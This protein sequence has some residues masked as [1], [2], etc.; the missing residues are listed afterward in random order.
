MWTLLIILAAGLGWLLCSGDAPSV[1]PRASEDVETPGTNAPLDPLDATGLKGRGDHAKAEAPQVELPAPPATGGIVGRVI[2]E[3]SGEGIARVRLFALRRPDE[4]VPDG[5][6]PRVAFSTKDGS[7]RFARVPAG[8]WMV[9]TFHKDYTHPLYG[10]LFAPSR[11]TNRSPGRALWAKATEIGGTVDVADAEAHIEL[12]LAPGARLNGRVVDGAGAPV[13]GAAV[14]VKTPMWGAMRDL[15]S[16]VSGWVQRMPLIQTGDDGAFSLACFPLMIRDLH[17]APSHERLVGRWSKAIRIADGGDVTLTLLEPATIEGSVTWSDGRPEPEADVEVRW[18]TWQDDSWF[19]RA[20]ET[21]TD[22][23]GAFRLER[24]PPGAIRLRARAGA[25]R[26]GGAEVELLDLQPGESRTGVVLQL[27]DDRHLRGVLRRPDGTPLEGEHIEAYRNFEDDV[28]LGTD[29]TDED[30]SFLIELEGRQP[31]ELWL[32]TGGREVRLAQDVQ[33]PRDDLQLTAEPTPRHQVTVRV[34][35]PDG[36]PVPRFR[37]RIEDYAGYLRGSHRGTNGAASR[38]VQGDGPFTL[39]IDRMQDEA[40]EALPYPPVGMELPR[41][42]PE[43]I[44]VRVSEIP[45]FLGRVTDDHDKPVPGI[46]LM[47]GTRE[48]KLDERGHFRFVHD[49]PKILRV[50]DAELILPPGYRD[51]TF[52]GTLHAGRFRHMWVH[53]GGATLRGKVEVAGAGSLEGLRI[54]VAWPP[55]EGQ[56]DYEATA[57]IDTN[58]AGEFVF[59]ALPE[60]VEVTVEI[61][62][63]SL[64]DAGLYTEAAPVRAASH[65]TGVVLRAKRGLT[66]TGRFEGP[67]LADVDVARLEAFPLRWFGFPD[68]ARGSKPVEGAPHAFRIGGLKSGTYRL[69]VFEKAGGQGMLALLPGVQAGAKDVVVR[70]PR[71]DGVITGSV[72]TKWLAETMPNRAYAWAQDDSVWRVQ[73]KID[74][75]GNFRFE[76]LPRGV[77]YTVEFASTQGAA[78]QMAS[79]ADVRPG[80]HVTLEPTPA[81]WITGRLTR[82]AGA[83]NVE[84]IWALGRWTRALDSLNAATGA[85]RIGPLAPGTYRLITVGEGLKKL[86]AHGS[87]QAGDKDVEI[88]LK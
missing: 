19:A 71:L 2:D 5:S 50:V 28:N 3:A 39:R 7:F 22:E 55:D 26:D 16:E 8:R 11:F 67:G 47:V 17:L 36:K 46:K 72:D 60:G 74:E 65:A 14:H 58:A 66:I 85:F 18:A 13:A 4:G 27:D 9:L 34:V 54:E 24:V 25:D 77:R 42:L 63:W 52:A 15:G 10:L 30:G 23:K 70:V 62:R 29:W 40:K 32:T 87:V 41:T 61:D 76:R 38:E 78:V 57:G 1:A 56:E 45:A 79:V 84:S 81:L 53:G 21:E 86:G 68:S 82:G 51:A 75:K 48:I 37:M 88:V 83:P 35:L 43:V 80:Q 20:P 49:D 59:Y 44:E 12:R 6:E 31:V 73:T 69:G 64:G 33:A